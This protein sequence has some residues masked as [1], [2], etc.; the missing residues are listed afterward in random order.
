MTPNAIAVF[1]FMGTLFIINVVFLYY[2]IKHG[3]LKK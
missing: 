2:V 3:R 1:V